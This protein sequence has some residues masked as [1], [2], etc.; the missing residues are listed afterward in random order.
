MSEKGVR[1]LTRVEDI[2]GVDGYFEYAYEAEF[3]RELEF[4]SFKLQ[5]KKAV[6]VIFENG[7]ECWLPKSQLR[8]ARDQLYLKKF[9]YNQIFE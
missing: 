6:L 4:I 9:I 2:E 1:E 3:Y 7:N 5:S 8:I